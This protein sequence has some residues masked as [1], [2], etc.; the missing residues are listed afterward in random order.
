[1]AVVVGDTC[2]VRVRV[3]FVVVVIV[4]LEEE[5]GTAFRFER[6]ETFGDILSTFRE[7]F[8]KV[9]FTMYQPSTPNIHIHI[10]TKQGIKTGNLE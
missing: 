5:F 1:M 4:V 2:P 10:H 8:C 7:K 6:F 9:P 3:L